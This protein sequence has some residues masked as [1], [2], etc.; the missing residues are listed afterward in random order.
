MKTSKTK[1]FKEHK[2]SVSRANTWD[3]SPEFIEAYSQ[4]LAQRTEINSMKDFIDEDGFELDTKKHRIID[5]KSILIIGNRN[6][7]FPHDR[8]IP[9]SYKTDCF[10]RLRRDIRNVEIVTYDELF[11][12]AFH[13]VYTEKIPDD[14][15]KIE[16]PEFIKEVLKF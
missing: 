4:T 1:I 15:F 9:N 16:A 13:I 3:F 10:E 2:T 8:S 11:E 7:E 6:L 5:P 14:W 12:R